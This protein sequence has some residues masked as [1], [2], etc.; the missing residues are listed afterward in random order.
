M[1]RE[2]IPLDLPDIASF[3]PR[4]ERPAPPAPEVAEA[5]EKAGFRTRHASPPKPKPEPVKEVFDARALRRSN[6]TAKLNIATSP[7]VRERFW[8]LAQEHD[9]LSGEEMLVALMD[10]FERA[11]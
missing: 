10:A 1:S 8:K 7:E 2:R 11:P 3:R 6:R 5:A 4:T 9:L